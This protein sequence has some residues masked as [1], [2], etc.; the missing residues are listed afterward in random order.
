[1]TTRWKSRTL[2]PRPASADR[3]FL[4]RRNMKKHLP[5]NRAHP[6]KEVD[7]DPWRRQVADVASDLGVA[8]SQKALGLF[9]LHA[10]LLLKW[11]AKTNLTA[12]TDPKQMAVK[13][14][15][16][17]LALAP[18]LPKGARMLDMGAGGGFPGLVIKAARP[19]ISV[20]LMD[21][22]RKK[23][24][25]LTQ[26]ILEGGLEG[27][28]AIHGRAQDLAKVPGFSGAFD[29]VASRAFADLPEFVRLALP[30]VNQNGQILA[31]KGPGAASGELARVKNGREGLYIRVFP[32]RL[33][34]NGP[35]RRIVEIRQTSPGDRPGPVGGSP[36]VSRSG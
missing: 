8:L 24:S 17:S 25:F 27:V 19:D 29:A 36:P 28:S 31:M 12:I 16:D 11:T 7:S 33:G 10:R 23:V 3:L 35:A 14:F 2:R 21:A 13:H 32:Y 9:S 5:E 15:A 6:E 4:R 22:V 1:M 34:K 20:T 26:V 30:F 18:F